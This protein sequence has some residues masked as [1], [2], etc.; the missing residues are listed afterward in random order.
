MD[1]IELIQL[2]SYTPSDM[3]KAIAAFHQLASPDRE[4]GLMDIIMFRD[5]TLKNDIC[6]FIGWDGEVPEKGKSPLGLQLAAT[7]SE[8]GRI[9]HSVWSYDARLK[10]KPRRKIR[11]NT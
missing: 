1:W 9:Y 7:F 2:R 8:F 3:D 10:L 11:A 5:S 4:K 6:I